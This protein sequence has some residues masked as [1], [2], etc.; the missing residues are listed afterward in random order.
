MKEGRSNA[1]NIEKLRSVWP[2]RMAPVLIEEDG[3][4]IGDSGAITRYLDAAYPTA[5]RGRRPGSMSSS[6]EVVSL[7]DGAL[8][9]LVNVGTRY[10]A[11]SSDAAWK[12]VRDEQ[13][14]RAQAALDTLAV[15]VKARGPQALT[16]TGW[17]G[18]D[19]WLFTAVA[20][21]DGLPARAST[22]PNAAQVVSLAWSL[23]Q[24]LVRWTE[25]FRDRAD[26]RALD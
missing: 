6:T 12:S 7:V 19:M 3:Q 1:A 13:V 15:R 16:E 22:N 26:V 2:L 4:V 18:A 14:G 25:A 8:D 9:I 11:L 23:P 5:P 10:F 24:P 21:L 17:S 20:W